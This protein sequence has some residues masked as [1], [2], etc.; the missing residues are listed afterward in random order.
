MAAKLRI[1][2]PPFALDPVNECLWSGSRAIKLRP[3]AFA[4][5]GHLLSQAGQLVTKEQLIGAVWQDTFVGDAVLKVAIRQIRE[6]LSDDPKSPRFIETSH[7]RGYRFIG[8]IGPD[9]DTSSPPPES[10][11]V[12]FVE[13]EHALAQMHT[14]LNKARGGDCQVVF[15]TGEAGIGKT[16]LVETFVQ[17]VASDAHGAD[18][19]WAVSGAVRDERGVPA[20]SWTR[21]GSCASTMRKS[22]T[23]CARRRRCG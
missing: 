9:A 13:R 21:F 19:P 7:R 11:A 6:A 15:V 4:V 8:Q 23:C 17:S 1:H 5:L 3:K 10:A 14:W 2:F 16:T 18:L 22:L 12:G 20:R